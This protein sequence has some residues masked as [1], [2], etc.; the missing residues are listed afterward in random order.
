MDLSG[1]QY[2]LD[3]AGDADRHLVLQLE[4]ILQR[5][6]KAVGPQMRISNRVD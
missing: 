3:D 4:D 1:L 6:V 5:T 2:R